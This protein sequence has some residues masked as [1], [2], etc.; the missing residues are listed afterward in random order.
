VIGHDR[1]RE[2]ASAAHD[3][4]L[5]ASLRPDLDAHLAGCAECLRFTAAL[6]PLSQT[7]AAAPRERAPGLAARV[8]AALAPRRRRRWAWSL[9][10]AATAAAVVAV[11]LVT[12]G[13]GPVGF[14]LPTA[15]AATPLL[16]LRS[17]YVEREVETIRTVPGGARDVETTREKIWF[18][19]PGLL[20]IER[21]TTTPGG[22]DVTTH[23]ERPGSRFTTEEGLV[24]GLPP[25]IVLPE[26]LSP[27]LAELG[28]DVGPGP[29]V[30]G[31]PTRRVELT[32][33]GE[34]REALVD[35]A[36]PYVLGSE[37][38]VVLG[39]SPTGEGPATERITKRVL[40]VDLD[41]DNPAALFE[42][43]DQS[44]SDAGFRE[45][46]VGELPTAP[47]AAPQGF[48]VLRAGRGPAGDAVLYTRGALPVLVEI[49]TT[50]PS[51]LE[52]N[53][54]ERVTV[55]GRPGVLHVYLYAAPHVRLAVGDRVVTITAPLPTDS[56]V[57]LA[58]LLYPAE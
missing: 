25:T 41:A 57:E 48:Q 8:A 58:G 53:R 7:V 14:P 37:Q 52:P 54:S 6:R 38:S 10:P 22:T 19:A 2:L 13:A 43:P 28:R 20:R 4:E 36:R 31:R 1:A 16:E 34:T 40:S 47:A 46:P 11:L 44:A 27:T 26:P 24:T 12:N 30:A 45:R 32:A 55:D 18:D 3:G 29:Q 56:L 17:V 39:K 51:E 5:A 15:G 9:A 50:S 49:T 35:A 23:I 21:T 33:G 42:L